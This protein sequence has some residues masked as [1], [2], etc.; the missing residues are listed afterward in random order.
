MISSEQLLNEVNVLLDAQR[1]ASNPEV[2]LGLSSEI[3]SRLEICLADARAVMD[4]RSKF[5]E[6]LQQ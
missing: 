3:L 6:L 4:A 2:V 5:E 1:L